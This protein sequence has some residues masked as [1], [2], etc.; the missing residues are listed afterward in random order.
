[1]ADGDRV[2]ESVRPGWPG[3]LND[4]R[5]APRRLAS[6]VAVTLRWMAGP[7]RRAVAATLHDISL[8]GA[9]VLVHEPV[10]VGEEVSFGLADVG[11]GEGIGASVVR[12]ARPWAVFPGPF[13]IGLR[14]EES[15]PADLF[16]AATEIA[17]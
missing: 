2:D 9:S 17:S 7:E 11:P 3:G 16:E 8:A 14:F 10:S 13:V 15:C 1:M 5:A 6:A 4:R 12:V